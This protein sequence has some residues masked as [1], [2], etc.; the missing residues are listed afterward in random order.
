M[1]FTK[2]K[3]KIKRVVNKTNVGRFGKERASM[4]VKKK[5]R[6]SEQVG[7]NCA[8]SYIFIITKEKKIVTKRCG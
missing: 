4:K 2:N 5:K 7:K 3:K 8:N 1:Y 6:K